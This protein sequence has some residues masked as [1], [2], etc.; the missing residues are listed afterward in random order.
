MPQSNFPKGFNAV[1]MRGLPITLSHPGKVFWVSN[2]SAA[3]MTGQKTGS[4]GNKGTFDEPFAT[5]DFA[6][7]RCQAGRGDVIVVKPGHTETYSNAT[8]LLL[9]VSGILIIGLG[10]GNMR[11]K[12]TLDT[13]TSATIPVS[14]ASIGIKNVIFSA[15]FA[16]IVSVFTLTTAKDF[17]LENVR[18]QATATD[19]NFIHVIDTNTTDNAADGHYVD[20]LDWIEPDAATLA[21]AL[22]DATQESW[23]FKNSYVN[24]GGTTTAAAL[25]TC[26]AGKFL[27][28]A[29]ITGNVVRKIGQTDGSAGVLLSTNVTTHSGF[30]AANY[31]ENTDD[32]ANILTTANAGFT[33]GP[34]NYHSGEQGEAGVSI[35]AAFNNA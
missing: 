10:S 25:F 20:G 17:S 28:N 31:S 18:V 14:A 11:P 4:D 30:I 13:A 6:V 9:D 19:M 21:Y 12:F 22:V 32:A 27:T 24:I 7:G 23:V 3:Q 1:T 16:D 2:A 33:Y 35:V 34:D 5:L 8:S 29:K 26:A 15:N